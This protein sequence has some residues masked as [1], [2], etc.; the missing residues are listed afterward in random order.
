M[1]LT[2]SPKNF[3]TWAHWWEKLIGGIRARR[4]Q[5]KI[6]FSDYGLDEG[7]ARPADADGDR[8]Q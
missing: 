4:G 5:G 8:R 1:S 7:M 6:A 3:W 2:L